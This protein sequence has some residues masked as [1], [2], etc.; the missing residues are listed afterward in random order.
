VGD[1]SEADLLLGADLQ[2]GADLPA[3][4]DLPAVVDL[5]VAVDLLVAEVAPRVVVVDLQF[6]SACK[7]R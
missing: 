5:P 3:A 1:P 2:V 4:V 7:A 6:H